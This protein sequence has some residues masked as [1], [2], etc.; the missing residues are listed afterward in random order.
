MGALA[1]PIGVI[2]SNHGVLSDQILDGIGQIVRTLEQVSARVVEGRFV[3]C[4]SRL[5]RDV[6]DRFAREMETGS[7]DAPLDLP[8]EMAHLAAQRGYG[9]RARSEIEAILA[10]V[11]TFEAACNDM[12]RVVAGLN[13]T[14][15]MCKVESGRLADRNGGLD[16]IIRQ[17]GAFQDLLARYLESAVAFSATLRTHAEAQAARTGARAA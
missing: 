7:S 16:E 8:G 3:A 1:G 2:A 15:M 17:L 10:R 11:Q 5:Q 12:R 9:A 4:S 6:V 13:I 14:R